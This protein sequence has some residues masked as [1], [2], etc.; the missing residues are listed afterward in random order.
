MSIKNLAV[1]FLLLAAVCVTACDEG[2]TV[3]VPGPDLNYVFRYDDVAGLASLRS[4]QAN[5]WILI[6]SDSVKGR[7]LKAFLSDSSNQKY[8]EMV[9]A[10]SLKSPILT[11][12]GGNYSFSGVDSV[13]ITYTLSGSEAEI[14]LVVGAPSNTSTD[15]IAFND[16]R[17]TKEQVYELMGCNATVKLYAAYNPQA[18]HCFLPGAVY[19]FKAKSVL[20]VKV[21]ALAEGLFGVSEQAK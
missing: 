16:V 4:A 20:S 7:D 11:V 15:T 6:A 5:E 19:N 8:S 9:A 18:Q 12:S 17:V 3:D 14:P 13:K 2:A 10:A 21:A 1:N